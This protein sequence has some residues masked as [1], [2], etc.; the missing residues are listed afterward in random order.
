M[1]RCKARELYTAGVI[2]SNACGKMIN[3]L[4]KKSGDTTK[5]GEIGMIAALVGGIVVRRKGACIG[6]QYY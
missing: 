4:L 1:D 5:M 6:W 2:K 3:Q